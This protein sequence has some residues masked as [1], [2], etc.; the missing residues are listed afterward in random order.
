MPVHKVVVLFIEG[1]IFIEP[2]AQ[3]ISS[4]VVGLPLLNGVGLQG[5]Y[6]GFNFLTGLQ[7]KPLPQPRF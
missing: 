3:G 1:R 2:S 6:P 5:F 4:P 7:A